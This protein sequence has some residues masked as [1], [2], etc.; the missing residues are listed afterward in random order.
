MRKSKTGVTKKANTP[1]VYVAKSKIHGRGLFAARPIRAGE[2]IGRVKARRTTT[3]GAYVLWLS[4]DRAVEVRCEL[5]FINHS[6]RPNASYYDSLEVI[7][8]RNIRT[9]EEITHNYESE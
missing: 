9:D 5:R 4:E 8:L 6:D 1:I 2:V 7:A 3:D